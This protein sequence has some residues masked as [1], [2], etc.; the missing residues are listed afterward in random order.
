MADRSLYIIKPEAMEFRTLIR[1]EI[2]SVGLDI[3]RYTQLIIPVGILDALYPELGPE[4]REATHRFMGSSD[5]EVGE[6]GG[7]LAVQMLTDLCG[8]FTD[9]SCCGPSTR[10]SRTGPSATR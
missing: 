4:L 8:G 2:R 9:P 1:D 5:C 6:V 10:A 3:L 7:A